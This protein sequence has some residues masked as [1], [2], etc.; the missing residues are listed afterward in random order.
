MMMWKLHLQMKKKKL[1]DDLLPEELLEQG[2]LPGWGSWTGEGIVNKPNAKKEKEKDDK[3]K[4]LEKK[5]LGERKDSHLKH[6][7]INH[8]R[9]KKLTKYKTSELPY[10]FTSKEAYEKSLKH[11][12]GKEWNTVSTHSAIIK[13]RINTKRGAIIEPIDKKAKKKSSKS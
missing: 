12:L 2:T 11:P 9:D 6:V 13:P 7:I 10:P 5:L 4:N 3:R 8:K 1:I